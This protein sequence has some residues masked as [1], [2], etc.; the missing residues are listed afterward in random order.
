MPGLNANK[1]ID[2]KANCLSHARGLK[3]FKNLVMTLLKHKCMHKNCF[4]VKL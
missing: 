4:L 2:L 1:Q 3:T